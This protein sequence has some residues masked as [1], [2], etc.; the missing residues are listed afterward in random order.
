MREQYDLILSKLI[1]KNF[2]GWQYQT[3]EEGNLTGIVLEFGKENRITLL[4]SENG[5]DLIELIGSLAALKK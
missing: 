1:D 4:R 2:T 3:D 5:F